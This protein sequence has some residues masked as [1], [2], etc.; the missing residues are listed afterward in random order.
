MR[1]YNENKNYLVEPI[2]WNKHSQKEILQYAVGALLYMP[3]TNIKIYDDIISKKNKNIKSLAL[4]LEDALGD[5]MQKEGE[6]SIKYIL[7]NL[8]LSVKEGLLLIDD[9]PLIFV[10]VKYVGQMRRLQKILGTRAL[11][12]LTGFILPK[13]D[14]HN[15]VKYMEEFKEVQEDSKQHLYIMP[16]LESKDAM[17]KQLRMENLM[18][19]YNQLKPFSNHVLNMRVGATDFSNLFGIRRKMHVPI[20]NISV[21][22]DALSDILNVFLR[23]YVCSG[24]V[25][26]YFGLESETVWQNYMLNEVEMD[27]MN[28]FIGKTCIHPNQLGI[29]QN[30]YIVSEEEY[31]DAMSIVGTATDLVAVKKGYGGNKMNEAKAH[32]NWAKKTLLLANIYGVEKDNE[33]DDENG[34]E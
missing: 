33:R 4:C 25:F 2:S 13:F 27:K 11:S 31:T 3:A 28:G 6:Q 16:I 1:Y 34:F 8:Y 23:N 32:I 22:A 12:M 24:P 29:V 21:V 19:I 15:V 26:E 9:I 5:D 14:K 30:A 10:R 18:F 20:Y 7:K 17:F